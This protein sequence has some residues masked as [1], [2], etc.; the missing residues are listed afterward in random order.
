MKIIESNQSTARETTE[1][2]RDMETNLQYVDKQLPQH[3][4]SRDDSPLQPAE[5]HTCTHTRKVHVNP[6]NKH[7]QTQTRCES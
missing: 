7:K 5:V 2:P 1:K 3:F 6:N 4:I